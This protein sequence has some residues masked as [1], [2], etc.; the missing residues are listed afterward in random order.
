MAPSVFISQLESVLAE[1]K[2]LAARSQHKDLSDLPMPD[3]QA[4]VIRG[5]AATRRIAGE[6]SPYSREIARLQEHQPHLYLHTSGVMGVVKGLLD[7]LK[8]GYVQTLVE[9]VHGELFADFLEM[10]QHLLDTG[11]KDAAAVIAGSAL[12]AHVRALCLKAGIATEIQR[13]DGNLAPKKADQM[14]S[15]LATK[16]SYEKLDQKSVTAWLDLRNKAAHG[17][18]GEYSA[19]QVAL[20]IAGVRDFIRRVPA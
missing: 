5:I 13:P 2:A 4:V 19:E 6:Q 16:G 8:S 11:F 9:L 12:E 15:E 7:D 3:R 1:Y 10:A 14:N 17:K 20:L 18:Y